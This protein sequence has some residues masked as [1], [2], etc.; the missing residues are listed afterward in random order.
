MRQ[1]VRTRSGSSSIRRGA[2]A[3]AF[4]AGTCAAQPALPSAPDDAPA[5]P[6]LSLTAVQQVASQRFAPIGD[7]VGLQWRQPIGSNRTIDITAWKRLVQRERDA[8]TLIDERT[9]IY[10]ARLEMRITARKS[11]ATELKAIG[12]QL[13]NG[14]KIMLRRKDGN[15]TLYYRQQF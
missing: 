1:E 9:P 10:G 8:L 13:D 2:I 5:A 14:A 4:F 3:L 6:Q 15:P 7:D 12:L 11:F